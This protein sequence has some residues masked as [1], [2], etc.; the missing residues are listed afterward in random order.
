MNLDFL[1]ALAGAFSG[2]VCALLTT[3]IGVQASR[4][5]RQRAALI[6]ATSLTCQVAPALRAYATACLSVAYDTGGCGGLAAAG[7]DAADFTT[8]GPVFLATQFAVAWKALPCRLM[9]DVLTFEEQARRQTEGLAVPPYA[10]DISA[11][12]LQRQSTYARLGLK[13]LQLAERLHA[14]VRLGPPPQ[15]EAL[16]KQLSLRLA[17]L[18]GMGQ[19]RRH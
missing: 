4:Q 7:P 17:E 9:V 14:H 15:G 11:F 19:R 8:P 3:R 13:A 5:R 6:D 18:Q 1:P 16:H 12:L 10:R 2:T